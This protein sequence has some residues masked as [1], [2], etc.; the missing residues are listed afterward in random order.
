MCSSLGESRDRFLSSRDTLTDSKHIKTSISQAHHFPRL[1]LHPSRRLRLSVHALHSILSS[2]STPLLK[3]TRTSLL[4]TLWTDQPNYVGAWCV[5]AFD[6]DRTVRNQAHR[7][8]E[9]VLLPLEDANKQKE[10]DTEETAESPE[11]INLVEQAESVTQFAFS[12][13]LGSS[14]N[15]TWGSDTPEDPAFL[16]TSALSALVYLMQKLP[17]PLPLEDNTVETLMGDELWDMLAVRDQERTGEREQPKMVRKA[18]YELLGAVSARK[19]DLMVVDSGEQQKE[20]EEDDRDENDDRLR[21]I[22]R[23]VLENC[24]TE[25]EGWPG[26]ITFLRREFL[27]RFLPLSYSHTLPL[28]VI[29]KLGHSRISLS[30]QHPLRTLR[31]MRMMRTTKR[32]NE[33][34]RPRRP[35]HL[36]PL[37]LDSSHI[38]LS[39]VLPTQLLSTPRFSSFSRLSLLRFYRHQDLSL[40]PLSTYSSKT[41]TRPIHLELSRLEVLQLEK[42]GSAHYSSASYSKLRRSK[43]HNYLKTWQGN[44]QVECGEHF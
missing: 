21:T 15:E 25:E 23:L 41:S 36:H 5:A 44:G 11:G 2:G 14:S 39:P 29:R 6:S 37:S 22:S 43:M 34:K 12:L 26:I 31:S 33:K 30:I 38:S 3:H 42:L 19:E 4:S 10:E 27:S 13:I 17:S 18:L 9:S 40:L 24:W 35:S 20:E 8:W 28:Q 16:R 7:T 1:A 32:T